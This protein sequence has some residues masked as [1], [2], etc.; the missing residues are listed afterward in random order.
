MIRVTFGPE[1]T[2]PQYVR[3][4]ATRPMFAAGERVEPGQE[5]LADTRCAAEMCTTGRCEIAPGEDRSKVY[6]Q[7]AIW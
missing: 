3:M 5:F 2:A 4:R 6:K 1:P 7:V